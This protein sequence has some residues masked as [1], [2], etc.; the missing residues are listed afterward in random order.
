MG[1][2]KHVPDEMTKSATRLENLID[3]YNN[4][5]NEIQNLIN[6]IHTSSA[7]KDTAMKEAFNKTCNGYM[8]IHNNRSLKFS[9]NIMKLKEKARCA[10]EH[11][12]A[13]TQGG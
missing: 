13:Y 11:E 2:Y 1:R 8:T 12:K 5:L 7:W 6:T 9:Y 4:K 3:E 10:E